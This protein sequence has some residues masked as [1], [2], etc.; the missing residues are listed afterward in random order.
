MDSPFQQ[1]LDSRGIQRVRRKHRLLSS[2][3][4]SR[5]TSEGN[6]R[7]NTIV[8]NIRNE[9]E[10]Q[11]SGS[12]NEEVIEDEPLGIIQISNDVEES[13]DDFITRDEKVLEVGMW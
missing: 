9:N 3:I 2:S 1:F 5:A 12:D 11:L 4:R 6:I 10:V 7:I 8:S 13:F